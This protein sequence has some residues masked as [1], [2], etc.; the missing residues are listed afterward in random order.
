M[1]ELR[2]LGAGAFENQH[3]LVSIR[4]VIL[5]ADDVAD[6]EVDVVGTG[7]EVVGGHAVG[8]EEGEVFDVAGGFDLLAVNG[9]RKAN[10][11]AGA[12][13]NTEAEGKG[14]SG[15]GSAVAL[16]AGKFAHAGVEEPGLIGAGFFAFS[17]V[18]WGEVAVSKA[19]LKNGVGDLAM[20]GQAF[21]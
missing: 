16:D 12:S 3:V 21:G 2:R 5:T 7:G 1:R 17:G 19:L 11:L 18:G 13:G 9:V 15:R 8:A 20:Q 4:Q 14:L 10:L 6:A